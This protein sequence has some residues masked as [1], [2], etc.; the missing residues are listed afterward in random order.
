MKKKTILAAALAVVALGLTA[1]AHAQSIQEQRVFG[2]IV[3]LDGFAQSARNLQ[4]MT[5]TNTPTQAE[6]FD[7]LRQYNR[8]ITAKQQE[9][10]TAIVDEVGKK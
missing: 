10:A 6:Y 2:V 1:P 4:A 5:C 8:L 9:A 3:S 7:C